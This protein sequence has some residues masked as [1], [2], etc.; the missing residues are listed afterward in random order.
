LTGYYNTF[1]VRIWQEEAGS[2]LR[3]YLR[4]TATQEEA[5]FTSIE[6]MKLFMLKYLSRSVE[7][8]TGQNN[9]IK[10]I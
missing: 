5:Y 1:V 4:H 7:N 2:V 6:E 8:L 9:P 10:P 3:G